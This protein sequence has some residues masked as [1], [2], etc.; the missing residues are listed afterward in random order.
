M[1]TAF[2]AGASASAPPARPRAISRW[3]FIVAVMV[4]LMVVVGGITRLTESG[5]SMVRWE[6]VSGIVPPLNDQQ[7][8]AEF[9]A[10]KAYPEYQK[11]NRG[12]DLAQFKSIFF[13]EY[14]H[15]FIARLIGLVFALPLL[16]FAWKR[17]IPPGYGKRLVALLALGGL[18]GVIGW[19][20]VASGLVDRPDVSHVR[21]AIHLSMAL[22]ILSGLIWTGLDL[23][24]LAR[25]PGARPAAYAG[26]VIPL[27]IV[28][29]CQIVLG[30]FTAG[31]DAGFA[32]NTWPMMGDHWFPEGVA[33][34]KPF[35]LNVVNNPIVVQFCHRTTA[36]LVAIAAL[37]TAFVAWRRDVRRE[38]GELAAMVLIQFSLGIATIVSGVALWIG[39]A[40]QA[41]A[42]L[43]LI[44]TVRIAHRLGRR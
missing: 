14:L 5:L 26:A 12:M 3:L 11:I 40:H 7:W 13:W 2:V 19:W 21:L 25:N 24:V 34:L 32:F 17:A 44:A 42:A 20:M 38:A 37:A 43:L 39:V 35:W 36:F 30:A 22:F 33:M 4:F 23:A 6:P 16:W 10:Y 27:T 31:L 28:L 1:T 9:D 18:Q 8:Q 15:R 29:A 41:G